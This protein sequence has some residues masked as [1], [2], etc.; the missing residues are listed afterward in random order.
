MQQ[1]KAKYQKMLQAE[2]YLIESMKKRLKHLNGASE[3]QQNAEIMKDYFSKRLN[4]IIADYLMRENYLESAR[5]F[6]ED[7]GLAVRNNSLLTTMD[8]GFHRF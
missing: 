8:I 6:I 1:V 4:R 5:V 7:S 3:S 2:D